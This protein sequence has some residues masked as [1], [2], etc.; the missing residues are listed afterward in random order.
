MKETTKSKKE[1]ILVGY[2]KPGCEGLSAENIAHLM[3]VIKENGVENVFPIDIEAKEVECSFMGFISVEAA[4]EFDYDYEHSGLRDYLDLLMNLPSVAYGTY[5]YRGI[6][7]IALDE[8]E[9]DVHVEC[10]PG[11][12]KQADKEEIDAEKE[13]KENISNAITRYVE[14]CN[15]HGEDITIQD[16]E[17]DIN[18]LF[19]LATV[20][21]KEHMGRTFKKCFCIDCI[22]ELGIYDPDTKDNIFDC[23]E[24]FNWTKAE[25]EYIRYGSKTDR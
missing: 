3:R 4:D 13:A 7:I 21:F 6:K 11:V 25:V 20:L 22:G 10:K 23:A 1:K 5:D 2:Q 18:A 8:S 14:V 9:D 17:F 24:E 12:P 19:D 16:V 15:R